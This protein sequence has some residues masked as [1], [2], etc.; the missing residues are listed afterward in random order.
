[1]PTV[2]VAL[3]IAGPGVLRIYAANVLGTQPQPQAEESPEAKWEFATQWSLPPDEWVD[4][5]A[6][7]YTGWRS[8]EPAGPYWGRTGRSAGW[9]RT[10]Q[11]F[12]NFRLESLYVG[13]MPIAFALLA[14]AAAVGMRN[15]ERGTQ[16]AELETGKVSARGPRSELCVPRSAFP[17]PAWRGE[18]LFWAGVALVTLLLSFGKYFPL[19]ALFYRLPAVGS[20]RN[21]N[22]FIQI[23]QLAVG[24]LAA[25]GLDAAVGRHPSPAAN[26]EAA[27]R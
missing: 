18:I 13:A 26:G 24:I 4:F 8:G 2:A 20:I 3:L 27:V 10:R 14:V 17:S 5:V 11:G 16:N 1:V 25:F 9:E 19:Y 22:K 21:P 6:P 12:M 23:F 7:G 15:A